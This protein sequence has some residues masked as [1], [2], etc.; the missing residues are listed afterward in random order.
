[1]SRPAAGRLGTA[2]LVLLAG[3]G[4][5][6]TALHFHLRSSIQGLDGAHRAGVSD[7]VAV[8][9]DGF[10]VPQV[11]AREESD[12]QYAQGW[13][14]ATHR[15]WQMEL[16][17]RVARGRL[18]ELFG[19]ETLETDRLLRTLD[20]WGAAGRSVAALGPDERAA[21]EAY[22][23]GVN[24]RLE[25]WDG[26]WP[27]EFVLLGIEPE[28]WTPRA[29]MAVGKVMALDLSAWRRELSRFGSRRVVPEEK[30]RVLEPRWPGW[31]PTV[32]RSYRPADGDA[33]SMAPAESARARPVAG[34]R[35][36][37]GRSLDPGAADAGS[38]TPEEA[39]GS[40]GADR[41]ARDPEDARAVAPD[42][43]GN[44]FRFLSGF[45][46]SASN[47][48]ALAG[49]RTRS[50][51]PLV[52]NDMHLGLRAP[53]LWYVMGLHAGETGLRVAGLTLPGAPGVVVGFNGG[54]AWSFTNGMVDDMDLAVETLGRG[55]AAYRDGE[56][57]RA[58]TARPETIRVRG[59]EEPVVHRVRETRRGP[60]LSDAL[61]GVDTALSAR[62]AGA[63]PTTEVAGL[64]AM[65]R[66]EEP[67]AF[68]GAVEAFDSPQQNVVFAATDGTLG[69]RLSG[70][71]PRP[72]GRTAADDA[73]A[74]PP[75]APPAPGPDVGVG[76][77]ELWPPG[78][79][80]AALAR[81][82]AGP[83]DGGDVLTG[84]G[85]LASANNLQAPGLFGV[86]GVDYPVPFRARRIVDRLSEDGAW[87]PEDA[88]RL[89]RDTRSLLADRLVGRA[90]SAARRAGADS[91]A[92]LLEGWDRRVD[93]GSRAAAVFYAWV[94][95]LRSL[96]AADELRPAGR[97]GYFP[98]SA[99]LRV[100]EEGDPA[101][102]ADDVTTAERETLPG[103]EERAL[104]DAVDATGLAPWGELHRERSAHPL[105]RVEW[106]DRL[107]GF[108]VGPYPSPGGPRT[109]RPDDYLRW[110]P[111]DTVSW[112]PPWTNEY[113]PSQRLVVSLGPGPPAGRVLLPTG[114]S[115]NPLDEH[116]RDMSRRWR[117]DG[118]LVELPLD[119]ER[120]ENR[121]VRRM[122]LEPR[123]GPPRRD[124]GE[125]PSR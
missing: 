36:L 64:L 101:G 58:L 63:R 9:T 19:E 6:L 108:H 72:G 91:V 124:R 96:V 78:S 59:R 22:A 79:H 122:R 115:G 51:H 45:T 105:G 54:V 107:L 53:A 106:L 90:A 89:Q 111:V 85:F 8:L 3:A 46:A 32:L 123:A 68:A 40:E 25:S 30:R 4:L 82:G 16:F 33:P 35:S 97:W 83:G 27:P 120:V 103:L 66:A 1:M 50:G 98:M 48:W 112:R 49:S 42:G 80:P 102:W 88:A 67:E 26:A 116:Y 73:P 29:S 20:L 14:H 117:G 93:R 5:G 86:L 57:W 15:L 34:G 31:G 74:K 62:W 77:L 55:G 24:D 71:V 121:A 10:A 81:P 21:L 70:R 84:E 92:D 125:T 94:Y 109:V 60:L 52:A 69:Y 23:E 56:G 104:G 65:N 7:T 17:R 44:P 113:G 114:Q 38:G 12:L 39:A 119:R 61:Q 18:S 100:A 75:G 76:P 13:L 87:T 28:P 2:A 99:L 118:E 11:F 37:A 41:G 95:R 43:P 110:Q 47:N